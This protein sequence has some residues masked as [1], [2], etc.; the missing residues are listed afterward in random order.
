MSVTIL[1]VLTTLMKVLVSGGSLSGS[2]ADAVGGVSE[3]SFNGILKA[4]CSPETLWRGKG[5]T[6]A[7]K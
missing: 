7:C 3:K 1:T 4:K 5:A 2:P 6:Q